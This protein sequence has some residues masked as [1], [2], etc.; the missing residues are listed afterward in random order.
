MVVVGGWSETIVCL[1]VLEFMKMGD[2]G[3]WCVLNCGL[4][5]LGLMK[6]KR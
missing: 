1:G 6:I 5:E 4:S 2:F 3:R